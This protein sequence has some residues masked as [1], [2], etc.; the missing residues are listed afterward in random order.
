M[1]SDPQPTPPRGPLQGLD[2]LADLLAEHPGGTGAFVRG[3]TVGILVGA[4]VAGVTIG[5]RL[6]RGRASAGS[7]PPKSSD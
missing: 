7:Q 2:D 5:R 6:R 4:A 3:L 1:S